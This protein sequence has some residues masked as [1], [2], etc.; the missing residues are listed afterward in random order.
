GR[1]KCRSRGERLDGGRFMSAP[2]AFLPASLRPAPQAP[3]PRTRRPIRWWLQ[4]GT[5]TAV[6]IGAGILL[7]GWRLTAV[8]VTSCQGLPPSAVVNLES[9]T[10]RWIPSLDLER[11]RQDVE[12]WPGITGVG[13]ELKLPAT[14]RI[15]ALPDEICA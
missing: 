5:F 1:R 6:F 11:I 7:A 14:L 3:S 15:Q 13:V 8:E 12:R 9:L 4:V 10:G 2:D